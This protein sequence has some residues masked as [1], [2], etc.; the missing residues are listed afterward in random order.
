MTEDRF[1]EIL[2]PYLLGELTAEEKRE[3]EQ[4]LEECTSC[5]S[6]LDHLRQTHDLLL[7]TSAIA[8]PPELKTRV[9]S[10]IRGETPASFR[11]RW[12]LWVPLAAA[13]LV[14]AFL[15]A[16]L[17]QLILGESSAGVSLAGT[18]LAP[19][20]SGVVRGE[21]VGENIHIRL[22]VQDM[23]ELREDEYYE[24]WYAKEDGERI[25]CGAFRT[26][27]EG[28]TTVDFTTPVNARA[29]PEIEVTREPDNGNPDSSGEK[30]LEGILRNA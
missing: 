12:R 24:M 2:G 14:A 20:A 19:D 4:H 13:L 29:Y 30:I 8:P 21:R 1:G 6:E 3:L 25:S 7:E 5:Q 22:E 11:S 23:P 28:T 9:L 27:P 18:A 10:E 16:E 17:L 26:E 15:G